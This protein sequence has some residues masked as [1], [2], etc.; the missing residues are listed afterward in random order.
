MTEPASELTSHLHSRS[1][2]DHG[3]SDLGHRKV[4]GL[5]RLSRRNRGFHD[6]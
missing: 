3:P 1:P 2:L 4:D 5:L 6:R